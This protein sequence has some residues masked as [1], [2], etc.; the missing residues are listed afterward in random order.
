M[1]GPAGWRLKGMGSVDDYGRRLGWTILGVGDLWG[2]R[3]WEGGA[4]WE[5]VMI[6]RMAVVSVLGSPYNCLRLLLMRMALSP[7]VHHL[8]KDHV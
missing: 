2:G 8:R 7:R 3:F 4:I 1:E 6:L 5:G